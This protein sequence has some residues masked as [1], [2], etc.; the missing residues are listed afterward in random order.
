M[1]RSLSLFIRIDFRSSSLVPSRLF[2]DFLLLLLLRQL[3]LFSFLE[4]VIKQFLFFWRQNIFGDLVPGDDIIQ[5]SACQDVSRLH[6]LPIFLFHKEHS[7]FNKLSGLQVE[8]SAKPVVKAL[9]ELHIYCFLLRR[10]L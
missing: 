6:L 1:R 8:D 7:V 4:Q 2:L 10:L 9:S 5:H 3:I